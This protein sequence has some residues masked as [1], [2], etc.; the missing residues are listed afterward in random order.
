M[1]LHCINLHPFLQDKKN[2]QLQNIVGDSFHPRKR[3]DNQSTANGD[4]INGA[5]SAPAVKDR[6]NC[7][8]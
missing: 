8:W 1:S 6:G 3:D 4:Q 7:L 5:L 2:C